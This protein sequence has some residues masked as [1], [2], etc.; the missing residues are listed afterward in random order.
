MKFDCFFLPSQRRSQCLAFFAR[1]RSSAVEI[2]RINPKATAASRDGDDGEEVVKAPVIADSVIVRLEQGLA[3]RKA[4]LVSCLAVNP[5]LFPLVCAGTVDGNIVVWRCP[6][7]ERSGAFAATD[8]TL[9]HATQDVGQ[10]AVTA[11]CFHP[12]LPALARAD[13]NGR[14]VLWKLS[15][16]AKKTAKAIASNEGVSVASC[17]I[18]SLMFHPYLPQLA[19]LSCPRAANR[20]T[21]LAFGSQDANSAPP[22][23]GS[24]Y[25]AS[26]AAATPDSTIHVAMSHLTPLISCRSTVASDL[27]AVGGTCSDQLLTRFRRLFADPALHSSYHS[28]LL[29]SPVSFGAARFVLWTGRA[30]LVC[31]SADALVPGRTGMSSNVA[32]SWLPS[33]SRSGFVLPDAAALAASWRLA[34]SVVYIQRRQAALQTGVA[35]KF[36]LQTRTVVDALARGDTGSDP[37]TFVSTRVSWLPEVG[38]R[39]CVSCSFCCLL[40]LLSPPVILCVCVCVCAGSCCPWLW[41]K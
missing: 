8:A 17:P 2:L 33:L 38:P 22:T 7:M 36:S 27:P 21:M 30:G 23:P 6:F 18:T 25:V 28:Q 29:S 9:V 37:S 11:V 41:S 4:G 16:K 12:T 31:V 15:V 19:V 34:K 5:G 10:P 39:G 24:D 13:A 40:S 1:S 20:A 3:Q 32:V 35:F 26:A 14:V